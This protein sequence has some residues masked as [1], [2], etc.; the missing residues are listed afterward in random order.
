[1]QQMPSRPEPTQQI[2]EVSEKLPSSLFFWLAMGSIATSA[3]FWLIGRRNWS[4]FLGQWAPTFL[5]LPL[6]Y[7]L[8][9]PSQERPIHEI[10]EVGRQVGR[11]AEDITRSR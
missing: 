4:L 10:R 3:F 1:M 6:F 2:F 5:I 8:L 7:K 11:Y 9:R